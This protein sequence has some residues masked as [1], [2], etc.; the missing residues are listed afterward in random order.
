[1]SERSL[2]ALVQATI[3]AYYGV[4]DAPSVDDFID[5]RDEDGAREMLLVR[6]GGDEL[7]LTLRLPRRA[8]SERPGFDALCQLVEGVSHFLF[9]AERARRE[10]PVTHLELELQ[11][12]VD[13]YVLFAHE[14]PFTGAFDP[15]RAARIR[16]HL[17]GSPSFLH[18]RGTEPGDR[19][20][21]ANDLA[22]RFAGRLEAIFATRGRF[23]EMRAA[24]RRFYGV[25]QTEKIQLARAA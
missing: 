21:M 18:P 23:G 11:A 5:A 1:M 2:P 22:A 3:A 13:K 20:R 14:G 6:D 17:F 9:L 24:L 16:E 4:E 7:E 19:Y 10:L 25:G 8:L 12:E 15:G